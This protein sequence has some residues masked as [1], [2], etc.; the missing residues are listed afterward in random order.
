MHK[1]TLALAL[2]SILGFSA[3][4]RGQA[5]A[6][7]ALSHAMSSSAGTAMGTTLGRATNQMAGKLGQQ[8]STTIR[9]AVTNV[10]PGVRGRTKVPTTQSGTS[11]GG[12][13]IASIQGAAPQQ[14]AP[15]CAPKQKN[16]NGVTA[17]SP[18]PAD[19]PSSNCPESPA[20]DGNSHPSAISLPA[21]K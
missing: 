5:A 6:E 7:A 1:F 9:P 14:S 15:A 10:K 4:A 20:S 18:A 19:G 16:E 13:M 3:G 17:I 8:T 21:A 11:N 2:T 12:S